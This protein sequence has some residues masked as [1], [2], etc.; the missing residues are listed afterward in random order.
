MVGWICGNPACNGREF[1][2]R[3]VRNA[4]VKRVHQKQALKCTYMDAY[5]QPCTKT[6]PNNTKL[7]KHVRSVHLN[8]TNFKCTECQKGF[9]DKGMLQRHMAWHDRGREKEKAKSAEIDVAIN[10]DPTREPSKEVKRLRTL[11]VERIAGTPLNKVTEFDTDM[12]I[13]AKAWNEAQARKQKTTLQSIRD[14]GTYFCLSQVLVLES[15]AQRCLSLCGP[16][17]SKVPLRGRNFG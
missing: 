4:H 13:A 11:E 3:G 8:E 17:R 16:S 12:K 1:K 9:L 7:Q 5:N 15:S 14:S 6:F 10:I 2:T